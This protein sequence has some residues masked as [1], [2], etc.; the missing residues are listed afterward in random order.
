MRKNFAPLVPWTS[1][2]LS[3]ADGLRIERLVAPS[4]LI[5]WREIRRGDEQ[6][7]L[8]EEARALQRAVGGVRR[9]SG[10]ARFVARALM[11]RLGAAQGPIL[12]PDRGAPIWPPGIVGSLAH[13]GRMAVACVARGDDVASLGV[14]VE[15]DEPLPPE[16]KETVA[17]PRERGRYGA[18]L[19]AGR[20]L[21]AAKEAVFKATFPL[22]GA[23]LD[24]HDIEVDLDLGLA[25]TSSGRRVKLRFRPSVHL[26]VLAWIDR[27]P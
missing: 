11:A 19:L 1:E 27:E 18:G 17:T 9:Q 21:F 14:D 12:R 16:L 4:V 26:V 2:L 25:T 24:F 7:L 10:A 23:W 20:W 3:D 8:P 6:A 15:P 5:G 13:D 22:D